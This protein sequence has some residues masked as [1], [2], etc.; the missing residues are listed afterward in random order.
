MVGVS[1]FTIKYNT[2]LLIVDYYSKFP[3]VRNID[4]LSADN[5]S[6]VVKIVFAEFWLP[7]KGV[8]DAGTSFISDK[9]RQFCRNLNI[10]QTI[11][12]SYHH[13]SKGQVET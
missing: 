8:P 6:R 3:V 4:G 9:F 13:Q 2:L 5:L 1:I 10:E 11:T 7:R 12:S